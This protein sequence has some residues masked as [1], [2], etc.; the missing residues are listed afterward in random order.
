[1]KIYRLLVLKTKNSRVSLQHLA[2]ILLTNPMKFAE[3][4]S[5]VNL[6]ISLQGLLFLATFL[7]QLSVGQELLKGN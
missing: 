3:A 4:F 2:T 5:C 6:L 1:M 7:R